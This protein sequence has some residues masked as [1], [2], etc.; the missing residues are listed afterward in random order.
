MNTL[1]AAHWF[2][3]QGFRVFPLPNNSKIPKLAG[4]QDKATSNE[5]DI[6]KLI[7]AAENF[8]AV[9]G[10]QY[11]VLDVDVHNDAEGMKSL[12]ELEDRIGALPP[13][14]TVRTASGGLHFYYKKPAEAKFS[15]SSNKLGAGL[16][17]QTGNSYMV[18]PPS[19]IDGKPYEVISAD[20]IVEAPALVAAILAL[21]R[22]QPQQQQTAVQ[23]Y[24]GAVSDNY[25]KAAID[26]ELAKL[27][28]LRAGAPGW[29]QGTY[30]VAC[31]LIELANSHWNSFTLA[32]AEQLLMSN[33][34]RDEGFR[35]ARVR[36]KWQSALNKIGS[37]QRPAPAP[38][39]GWIPK[40]SEA[41][42]PA[43]PVAPVVYT[44]PKDRPN[45]ATYFQTGIGL[46]VEDLARE[47]K[48]GFAIGNNSDLWVY[49]NGIYVEDQF[50]LARRLAWHLGNRFRPVHV[51]AVE[52]M[53]KAD[54]DVEVLSMEQ[55][56]ERYINL[57]NGMYDWQD[58]RLLDHSPDYKSITQLPINYDPAATCP[59]FDNYLNDVLPPDAIGAIWE[60]IGYML[61]FGNPLQQSIL[62]YGGGGNGKS[63]FLRVLQRLIGEHNVS[64][65]ALR[66][67]AE[68][69][70]ALA[71]LHGKIAN[72]AGDIDSKYLGDASKFKQVV[73]GDL[74]EAERKFGQPFRFKPWA[75]PIFSVNEFWKTSDTTHGYFRRW[76]PI[77]FPN[78]VTKLPALNEELLF[79]EASGIFNKAMIGLKE[80]M[81]R[82]KFELPESMQILKRKMEESSDII[83]DWIDQDEKLEIADPAQTFEREN[84]TLVY[85][86][87]KSWALATTHK[88]MSSTN[89][90][91]RIEALGFE[92]AISQG[93]R[94][95][96]GFK[97]RTDLMD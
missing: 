70:F 77:P 28:Q 2:A 47:V 13:T 60:V 10:E 75:V 46:L 64:A 66:Q 38:S 59:H 86:R 12:S 15:K 3:Q 88:P 36:Q 71:A 74:I 54:P 39:A 73:G 16:D 34:P 19:A 92:A 65:L 20:P 57:L 32:E 25:T 81:L 14:F 83:A 23:A 45:P 56:P 58:Q 62:L 68:E 44:A 87:F 63:T 91:K 35:D 49:R 76:L 5:A 29:D 18:A 84:R 93:N 50:E 78:D 95:L 96:V 82:S 42:P 90:Y 22:P 94:Q 9:V 55:P 61:M 4:W 43:P 40:G 17:I 24:S 97:I 79:A 89:F 72:I 80:L 26:A 1:Q 51:A 7:G 48:D 21:Q 52:M 33:A 53:I 69:R 31:N 30:E 6:E 11:F 8:G 41:A 67:I 27:A 37:A 85:N